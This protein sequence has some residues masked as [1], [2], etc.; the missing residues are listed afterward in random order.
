[1]RSAPRAGSQ[2][3]WP[4]SEHTSE[5]RTTTRKRQPNAQLPAEADGDPEGV[6][7]AR[8][9]VLQP[10]PRRRV[11]HLAPYPAEKPDQP[12]IVGNDAPR[13]HAPEHTQGHGPLGGKE[14]AGPDAGVHQHGQDH[15]PSRAP[16]TAEGPDERNLVTTRGGR[17]RRTATNAWTGG[18]RQP[19]GT[20]G[21]V[22]WPIKM[23]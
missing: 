13:L 11:G 20:E 8:Q 3:W 12:R 17:V 9:A 21:A 15:R 7:D 1:M 10:G 14:L 4:Q 16:P 19:P 22:H 23:E 5:D 18:K 6:R 2:A